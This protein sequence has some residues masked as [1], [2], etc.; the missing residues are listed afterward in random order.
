VAFV[1]D[2]S[3]SVHVALDSSDYAADAPLPP[4][5]KMIAVSLGASGLPDAPCDG[6]L[7]QSPT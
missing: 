1:V 3:M 6:Q 5:L 4:A 2:D 7:S